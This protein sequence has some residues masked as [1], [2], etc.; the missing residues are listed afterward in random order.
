MKVMHSTKGVGTSVII[1]VAVS[2]ALIGCSEGNVIEPSTGVPDD[3][4]IVLER[5]PGVG[6]HPRY[7]VSV[8]AKGNIEYVG[9]AHVDVVGPAKATADAE[10]VAALYEAFRAIDYSQFEDVYGELSCPTWRND[11][12]G[13]VTALTANGQ[14]KQVFRDFGCEDIAIL[15]TLQDLECRIDSVL[16]TSRWTGT[17]DWWHWCR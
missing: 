2:V 7:D 1:V 12:P 15:D 11:R 5:W 16:A 17:E 6:I 13:C 14:T 4:R 8:D 9:H 3:L 10:D